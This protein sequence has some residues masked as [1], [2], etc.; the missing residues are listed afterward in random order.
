MKALIIDRPWID[1][2]LAGHKTWEMRSKTVRLRGPIG[3]IRKGSG[4]VVGTAVLTDCLAPLTPEGFAASER[5]HTIAPHEQGPA[6]AGNWTI[7]WV[8]ADARPLAMPVRYVHRQGAVVW[9]N[10]DPEVADAVRQQMAA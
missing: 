6:I 1:R 9:V 2:I 4:Q 3:L 7:P 5:H 10:L 8:L